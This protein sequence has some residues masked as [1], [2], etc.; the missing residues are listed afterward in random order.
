MA[1][2]TKNMRPAILLFLLS[3]TPCKDESK[4]GNT[5]LQKLI[6]LVQKESPKPIENGFSFAP[7]KYGP[8]SDEL[9]DILLSL[10][11]RKMVDLKLDEN[12]NI[13]SCKITDTGVETVKKLKDKYPD[14][15]ATVSKI[16]SDYGVL[17]LDLLLLYVYT[18]YPDFTKRSEIKKE[19]IAIA[20][21]NFS[22]LQKKAKEFG[23]KEEELTVVGI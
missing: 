9:V 14:L 6:F 8:Y 16:V 18:K 10:S 7:Y 5:R 12:E 2:V 15:D 20:E 21:R 22:I 4:L 3:K 17:N 11:D 23:F 19:I 1:D 13:V